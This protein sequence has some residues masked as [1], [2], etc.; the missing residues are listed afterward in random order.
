MLVTRQR[1]P[2]QNPWSISKLETIFHKPSNSSRM[3]NNYEPPLSTQSD[4]QGQYSP[5][6]PPG[7]TNI[8]SQPYDHVASATDHSDSRAQPRSAAASNNTL[9][10]ENL[11]SDTLSLGSPLE[12]RRSIDRLG[13]RQPKVASPIQDQPE[14]HAE[15]YSQK[16]AESVP[17]ESLVSTE[18]PG[19]SLGSNP[20][21]SVSSTGQTS[22]LPT[23]HPDND[24][25][26]VIKDEDDEVLDDE[27]MIEG[28]GEG[29]APSQPQTAAER[30]AQRRKMKRF[31]YLASHI[32]SFFD[33][34]N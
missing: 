34:R 7:D 1:E 6:L 26:A 20:L 8:F 18:T 13:V 24:G 32:E 28:D 10:T 29:D 15:H 16:P 31:R 22:E 11:K 17:D 12:H 3:S 5:F 9:D 27:E 33:G 23:S 4:W 19:M 25:Q 21:S 2:E 30:T 14:G